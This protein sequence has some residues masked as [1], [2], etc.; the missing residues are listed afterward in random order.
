MSFVVAGKVL[1]PRWMHL[2]FLLNL[3]ACMRRLRP[4]NT[5]LLLDDFGEHTAEDTGLTTELGVMSN[6]EEEQRQQGKGV[7]PISHSLT[8]TI[9]LCQTVSIPSR[10]RPVNRWGVLQCCTRC[11]C[12]RPMLQLGSTVGWE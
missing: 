2:G 4:D 6:E 3:L 7:P 8:I 12:L 9:Q 5:Y 1:Q 11:S 10:L